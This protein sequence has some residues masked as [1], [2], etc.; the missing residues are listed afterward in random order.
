VQRWF[1]DVSQW[2]A[3]FPDDEFARDLGRAPDG[4]K[5]AQFRS[6]VLDRTL[7]VRITEKPGLITYE[8]SGK[9]IST[10]GKIF[11]YPLGP[12]RTRIVMQTTGELHGALG[13]FAPESVK[14]K[15][16]MKKLTADLNAAVSLSNAYAAGRRARG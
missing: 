11:F 12:D 13:V 5:V 1:S 4:R 6:K 9:G 15:K 14:R 16:A 2:K 7:T 10:Q 8:G 3:R